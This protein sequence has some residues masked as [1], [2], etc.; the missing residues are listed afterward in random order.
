MNERKTQ[1]WIDLLDNEED[2]VGSYAADVLCEEIGAP[3][4]PGLSNALA[5]AHENYS[6]G[7]LTALCLERIGGPAAITALIQALAHPEPATRSSAAWSLGRMRDPRALEALLN[8]LMQTLRHQQPGTF[9][10]CAHSLVEALGDF[11]HNAAVEPLLALLRNPEY[12]TEAAAALARIGST[13]AVDPLI[14]ILQKRQLERYDSFHV[15]LRDERAVSPLI[16]LLQNGSARR[17]AEAAAA[18]GRIGDRRAAQPLAAAV[19]HRDLAV[20]FHAGVAVSRLGGT[21]GIRA[22]LADL[23]SPRRGARAC[24]AKGLGETGHREAIDPLVKAL[25]DRY[26]IVR[27]MAALS[28][29]RLGDTSGRETLLQFVKK[30]RFRRPAR[31]MPSSVECGYVTVA[32]DDKAPGNPYAALWNIGGTWA[33]EAWLLLL[34]SRDRHTQRYGARAFCAL[35]EPRTAGCLLRMA[36]RS[37]DWVVRFVALG[38]LRKLGDPRLQSAVDAVRP[39]VPADI[40]RF[41]AEAFVPG[42]G[43]R[44]KQTD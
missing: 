29:E 13:R 21:A 24:A 43:G 23:E 39:A 1:A 12:R 3:A 7:L 35:A 18:L 34:R 32:P 25:R 20:R 44:G 17:R 4:V 16:D 15:L 28:L 30:F 6:T 19:G 26:W 8:A 31:G 36:L 9:G 38:A 33:T 11:G 42:S 37:E 5:G 22:F 41:L 27:S 14:D 2:D 10:G 40:S